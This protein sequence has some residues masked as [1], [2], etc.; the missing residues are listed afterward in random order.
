M[1]SN[2]AKQRMLAGKPALGIV[3]VCGS[4]LVAESLSLIGFDFV[5]IDNQ[6]GSWDLNSTQAAFHGV[7]LGHAVPMAR[8]QQNDFYAIGRLLDRGALGIVIP[9]VGSRQE[10]EASAFATHYP[11][12]GG[13]SIGAFAADFYGASDY[14][15][16]VEQEV[17]LAVQI[18]TAPG[19]E[20]VEEILSVAGVD[21]CW[22]GPMDLARSL[23][24]D[25][26]TTAGRRK[27]EDAI[28]RILD[29]C[30]KAGKI[31]GIYGGSDPSYWLHK[32]FLFVTVATDMTILNEATTA[33]LARLR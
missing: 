33:V 5:L 25:L 13:R 26:G 14:I 29:A 12:R 23:R 30:H 31:P 1:R 32:G 4:P 6:H 15:S 10:A 28:M 24:L 9:M 3:S 18:E 2:T 27:H 16:W 17:F 19:L 7:C 21:G 11:P 20:H 8:V 22:I